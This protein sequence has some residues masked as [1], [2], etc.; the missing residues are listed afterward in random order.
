MKNYQT[1]EIELVALNTDIITTSKEGTETTP[2]P[3]N[4]GIWDLDI[5]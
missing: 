1:P 4:G 5:G 3:E 2:Y